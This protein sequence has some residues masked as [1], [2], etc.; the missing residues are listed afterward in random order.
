LAR[1]PDAQGTGG[2]TMTATATRQPMS[3]AQ[4]RVYDFM[5]AYCYEYG[6]PPTLR[7]VVGHF[8][9]RSTNSAVCHF[10]PLLAK[11]Y[12]R[13]AAGPAGASR[14][15]LPADYDPARDRALLAECLPHLPAG[16]AGR[17][18]AALGRGGGG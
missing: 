14:S 16:L 15:Y 11:G 2:V 3:S 13:N 7:D 6:I 9:W 1:P 8:G 12:L 18:K 10:R 17:V 4:K 5:L